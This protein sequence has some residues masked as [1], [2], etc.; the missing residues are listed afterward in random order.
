M[1]AVTKVDCG[2]AEGGIDGL[3]CKA[4]Q[5]KVRQLVGMEDLFL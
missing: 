1:H 4:V 3:D 2:K 5:T